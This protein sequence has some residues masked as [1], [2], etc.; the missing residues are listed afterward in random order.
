MVLYSRVNYPIISI[1]HSSG[2]SRSA[3]TL[4]GAFASHAD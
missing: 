2:G 4:G 3:Y 1:A